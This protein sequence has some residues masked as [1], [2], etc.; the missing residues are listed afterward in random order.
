MKFKIGDVVWITRHSCGRY[1][2]PTKVIIQD[3]V[4]GVHNVKVMD[5]GGA[6]SYCTE[7]QLAKSR[8]EAMKIRD[9][10]QPIPEEIHKKAQELAHKQVEK[11]IAN[12]GPDM[13]KISGQKPKSAENLRKQELN[14]EKLDKEEKKK[15]T[16]EEVSNAFAGLFTATQLEDEHPELSAVIEMATDQIRARYAD[17]WS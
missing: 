16:F 13:E 6:V 3:Y 17:G 14:M 8:A 15:A 11:Y 7:S 9:G 1:M 12:G 4:S 2:N 5:A 10:E